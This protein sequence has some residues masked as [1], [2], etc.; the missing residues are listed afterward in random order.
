MSKGG[1]TL[2]SSLA[3]LDFGVLATGE[4]RS[5]VLTIWNPN[6]VAISLDQAIKSQ[7]DDVTI[8]LD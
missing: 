7:L 1:V 2:C 5:K 6:S 3:K 8:E 4:E